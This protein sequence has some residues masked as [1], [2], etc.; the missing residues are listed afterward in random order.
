MAILTEI[1]K[2]P[3]CAEADFSLAE[4]VAVS[5]ALECLQRVL[6]RFTTVHARYHSIAI[7]AVPAAAIQMLTYH[8]LILTYN[9]FKHCTRLQWILTTLS[10]ERSVVQ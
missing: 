6:T 9:T 3:L 10:T 5:P 7:L 4:L 8:S 2:A 1:I